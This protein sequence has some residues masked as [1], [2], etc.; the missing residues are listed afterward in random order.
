[1]IRALAPVRHESAVK[2]LK[3]ILSQVWMHP[4]E[5]VKWHNE[6]YDEDRESFEKWLKNSHLNVFA[7]FIVLKIAPEFLQ[8][9][10]QLC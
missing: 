5:I 8:K 7:V 6:V 3:R 2:Q 1:M 10:P 9:H 4:V